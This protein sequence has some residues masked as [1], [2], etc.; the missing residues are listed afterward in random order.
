MEYVGEIL[1]SEQ[2]DLRDEYYDDVGWKD[3]YQLSCEVGATS[4]VIDARL[5][6]RSA[7]RTPTNLQNAT[8]LTLHYPSSPFC[9]RRIYGS[10]ARFVNQSCEP[11]V[12][13]MSMKKMGFKP[14]KY[15]NGI[16]SLRDIKKGEELTIIYNNNTVYTND[17]QEPDNNNISGKCCC[18]TKS[19]VGFL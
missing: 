10:V 8:T 1:T 12:E 17:G 4:K 18:G 7:H 11:N 6:V 3:S 14:F 19:C 5:V 9:R 15:R 13:F 16:V 2:V